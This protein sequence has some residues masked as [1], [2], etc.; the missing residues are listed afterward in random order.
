[1]ISIVII[2]KDE[3]S[4]DYTITDVIYQAKDLKESSEIV[5]V[6]ASDSRLDH[7][8]LR[9]EANVRWMQFEQPSGVRV[10]IPHQRNAGVHAAAG[11]IIVFTDAGCRPEPGWLACLV[12]PL[13]QDEYITVGLTLATSGNTGLYDRGARQTL[14]SRYV[15]ECSTINLA[16]RRDV[17]DTIGGFDEGF[18]Y[19]SDVDF[20]WRLTDAGYQI[21][22]VPNAV[23][24]HDWGGWQRQLRRSYVYGKARTRLYRK[25]RARLRHILRDDPMVIV[26]PVFILGLPLTLFFPLYPAL[27]LVPAW[28]N[29]SNGVIRV[30]VDHL[31]YGVGVLAELVMR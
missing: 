10:S 18:A 20:T 30:M 11:E 16:F 15:R 24:R 29:R 21:R 3:P 13:L 22:S 12:S 17:F 7:I 5:I 1:M 14:E 8:R 27:L 6:D 26:Y 25:H 31:V 2:S 23:I 4:L 28:R 9:H 19:G